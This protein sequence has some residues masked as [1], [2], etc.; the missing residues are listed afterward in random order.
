[1]SPA[2]VYVKTLDTLKKII[3][4][5]FYFVGPSGPKDP[6]PHGD[7]NDSNDS[8][9]WARAH[10]TIENGILIKHSVMVKSETE[11][12]VYHIFIYKG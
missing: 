3:V 11:A 10:E 12:I 1:M 6:K 4:F 9:V 2:T 7:G 5:V 8:G